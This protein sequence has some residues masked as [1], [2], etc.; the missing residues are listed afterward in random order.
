[1]KG[2]RVMDRLTNSFS[3]A[4]VSTAV[5][6]DTDPQQSAN[7]RKAEAQTNIES[8]LPDTMKSPDPGQTNSTD[9]LVQEAR[10]DEAEKSAAGSG[11]APD[12]I[13]DTSKGPMNGSEPKTTTAIPAVWTDDQ[14]DPVDSIDRIL[15]EIT[16]YIDR[17]LDYAK[18]QIP[19]QFYGDRADAE[20]VAGDIENACDTLIA[21]VT[22]LKKVPW[23]ILRL[24]EQMPLVTCTKFK[25][26][27]RDTLVGLA[28]VRINT[29]RLTIHDIEIHSRR[30]SRWMQMPARPP[31][32]RDG[33]AI[34]DPALIQN[35]Y[36]EILKFEAFNSAV[37]P[38]LLNFAP[39][40]FD[41]EP[42]APEPVPSPA[43]APLAAAPGAM[44]DHTD[45]DGIVAFLDRRPAP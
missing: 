21:A 20:D 29:I 31:L 4:P 6:N 25:P 13:E 22:H 38:A 9:P 27:R 44:L 1:M 5:G 17:E 26:K 3:G 34:R 28:T 18:S 45:R 33:V 36:W 42:A 35:A 32:D 8:A 43:P 40:A 2:F 7:Q 23:E 41:E 15:G 16:K 30:E 10:D 19:G 11:V 12:D 37:I 14:I 24:A 39:D